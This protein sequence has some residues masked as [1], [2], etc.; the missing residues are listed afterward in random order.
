MRTREKKYKPALWKQAETEKLVRL[1]RKL[2]VPVLSNKTPVFRPKE[3]KKALW[4]TLPG[5]KPS[6]SQQRL[7]VI[8][9]QREYRRMVK[10]RV[11]VNPCECHGLRDEQG[12][13]IC[14]KKSHYSE[15][16]HHV[17]GRRGKLLIDERW[18]KDAC[19]K[20]HRWIHDHPE[21]AQKMKLL[22]GPGQW[23]VQPE[24]TKTAST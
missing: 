8:S 13:R 18:I 2:G 7:E 5:Q 24:N 11:G 23:G 6:L 10:R 17:R 22:A 19:L 1:G 21:Q 16:L 12:K 4:T 14:H 9:R 3:K 20:S 15:S